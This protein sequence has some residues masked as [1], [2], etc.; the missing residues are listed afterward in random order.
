MLRHTRLQERE[1]VWVSPTWSHDLL[2]CTVFSLAAG[3]REMQR[4]KVL[5]GFST[6]LLAVREVGSLWRRGLPH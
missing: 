6:L 3:R 4:F 2:N 1:N 5:E